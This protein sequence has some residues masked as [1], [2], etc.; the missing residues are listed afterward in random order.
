M[1]PYFNSLKQ[2]GTYNY[3]TGLLNKASLSKGM[4]VWKFVMITLTLPIPYN[5]VYRTQNCLF[6]GDYVTEGTCFF[7]THNKY[8]RDVLVSKMASTC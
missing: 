6:S 1:I 2:F 3:N 7:L 5:Q 4:Y 8:Y